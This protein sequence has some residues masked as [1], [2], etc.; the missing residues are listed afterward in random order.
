MICKTGA[1]AEEDKEYMYK[2]CLQLNNKAEN[3]EIEAYQSKRQPKSR[4]V[5]SYNS[6]PR[7]KIG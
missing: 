2:E 6:L 7:K 1:I 4:K 5:S 3:V